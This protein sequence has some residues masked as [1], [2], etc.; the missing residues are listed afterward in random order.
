MVVAVVAVESHRIASGGK[1]FTLSRTYIAT[2]KAFRS[3]RPPAA[4]SDHPSTPASQPASERVSERASDRP[5]Q[6]TAVNSCAPCIPCILSQVRKPPPLRRRQHHHVAG[7]RRKRFRLPPFNFSPRNHCG[8]VAPYPSR[9]F[10]S[11]SL[12]SRE[13]ALYFSIHVLPSDESW[14]R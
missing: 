7:M 12:R 5:R 6:R 11:R 4:P 10:R 13:S 2:R 9:T 14:G 3:T 8:R 1:R